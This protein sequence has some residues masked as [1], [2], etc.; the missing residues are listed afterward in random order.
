MYVNRRAYKILPKNYD[1]VKKLL[2]AERERVGGTFKICTSSF[3]PYDT[4]LVDIEFESYE[5]YQKF[6]SSY[7]ATP[8]SVQFVEKMNP[9]IETGG[10]NE[11]WHVW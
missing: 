4:I 10:T 11:F 1:K 5:A 8:E 9:L 7:P 3:G 6:S 2:L